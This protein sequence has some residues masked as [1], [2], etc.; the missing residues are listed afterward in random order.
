MLNSIEIFKNLKTPIVFAIFDAGSA[1]HIVSWIKHTKVQ[2]IYICA[3]GPAKL[4]VDKNLP[5][6]SLVF[7]LEKALNM[8][9]TLISG[10]GWQSNFEYEAISLANKKKIYSIA[11]LDHWINYKSRFIRNNK[12]VLP[13]EIWVT[14]THAKIEAEREFR[15][16]KCNLQP[17][18]Y[19]AD[20][21]DRI[22]NLPKK[23]NL[24]NHLNILYI[25][26][27]IINLK[28]S[29]EYSEFEALDYFIE[30]ISKIL[31]DKIIQ[32]R[33]TLRLH[34]SENIEKYDIWIKKNFSYSIL[35]DKNS[36]L[37]Q[38][39]SSADIVVGRNSYALSLAIHVGKKVISAIP[40]PFDQCIL[41]YK[42]ILKLSDLIENKRTVF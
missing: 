6:L 13:K 7:D 37:E 29:C 18:L 20:F 36:S 15:D 12:L 4:I 1:N 5:N 31:N 2:P 10:S 14:D 24:K 3:E 22:K 23:I 30:N 33:I 34:P 19:L 41:P 8:S 32:L 39:I 11:V 21:L 35:L 40:P 26:E 38:L 17:N 9:A 28:G 16:I 42:E 27:P 25:L